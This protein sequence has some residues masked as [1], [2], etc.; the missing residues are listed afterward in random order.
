MTGPD[1][2]GCPWREWGLWGKHPA[3]GDFLSAR[4]PDACRDH[5][6]PWLDSTLTET[7]DLL[8][9]DWEGR[10]DNAF[11][12]RFW[13]GGSIIRS[14]SLLGVLSASRDRVGRRYPL[15]LIAETDR[16]APVLDSRQDLHDAAEALLTSALLD[17]ATIADAL[18]LTNIDPLPAVE[19]PT[20]WA[21]NPDLGA[22]TFLD[23]L[24]STDYARATLSRS[25]WWTASSADRAAMVAACDG[26]PDAQT[27]A[28]LLTGV[29]AADDAPASAMRDSI[30]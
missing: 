29:A 22:G 25:Y 17:D 13:I 6:I 26:L 10:W 11:P 21:A 23:Q 19:P 4:L 16:S 1:G 14:A 18:T 7:R 2:S 24:A 28:W 20:F 8:G 9:A 30:G 12:V 27:L 3:H 15:M 5:V